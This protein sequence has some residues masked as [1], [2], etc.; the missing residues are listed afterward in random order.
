VQIVSAAKASA[1]HPRRTIADPQAGATATWAALG[2]Y[3]ADDAQSDLA[4]PKRQLPRGDWTLLRWIVVR[5]RQCGKQRP[6][7][8]GTD[9]DKHLSHATHCGRVGQ[10]AFGIAGIQE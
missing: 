3:V 10:S 1:S 4:G 8:D 6:G 7:P 5:R 2:F 9:S